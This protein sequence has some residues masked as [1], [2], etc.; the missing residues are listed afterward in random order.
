MRRQPRRSSD[1]DAARPR[2][3]SGCGDFF[4]TRGAVAL[5]LAVNRPVLAD[6]FW[7]SDGTAGGAG[8]FDQGRV[9][10]HL[11]IGRTLWPCVGMRGL[12]VRCGIGHEILAQRSQDVRRPVSP[13]RRLRPGGLP[14]QAPAFRVGHRARAACGSCRARLPSLP[15]AGLRTAGAPAPAGRIA[16]AQVTRAAAYTVCA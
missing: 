7:L 2:P 16:V 15:T 11:L 13:R 3:Q 10:R 6:R 5:L 8:E 1:V 12:C 9:R 14:S 4:S